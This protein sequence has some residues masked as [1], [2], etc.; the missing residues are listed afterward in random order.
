[1]AKTKPKLHLRKIHG[2]SKKGPA[3]YAERLFNT[4]ILPSIH[5]LKG[6]V[7]EGVEKSLR[8]YLIISLVSVLEYF[9][10][11]QAKQYV[12]KYDID[13]SALGFE[14]ELCFSVPY[15]DQMLKGKHLTKGNIV[16]SSFNFL[17]LEDVN[18]LFS[19]MLK[20][21]FFDYILRLNNAD[22]YAYVSKGYP[23]PINYGKLIQAFEIRHKIVHELS[24]VELSNSQ[25]MSLWDNAM[26]IMDVG[27]SLFIP[28]LQ[29]QLKSDDA[30]QI[31]KEQMTKLT[32]KSKE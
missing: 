13:V 20:I 16:A 30:Y 22:K 11:S 25:I 5:T 15:L 3:R 21:D 26:N 27:T 12:D 1:M 14:G 2:L 7:E 17:N 8:K 18:R 24:D 19:K 4:E 9:F 29:E 28:E 31:K 10:K 32:T 6:G 23:K